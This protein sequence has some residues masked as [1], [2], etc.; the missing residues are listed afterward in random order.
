MYLWPIS[1]SSLTALVNLNGPITVAGA[2]ARNFNLIGHMPGGTDGH[3]QLSEG[4]G[5]ATSMLPSPAVQGLKASTPVPEHRPL[6][7]P[8]F[9]H[10]A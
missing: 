1:K 3:E 9:L 2:N 5:K 6:P 10:L 8:D 4:Q 7:F